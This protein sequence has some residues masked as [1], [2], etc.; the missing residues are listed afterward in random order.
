MLCRYATA[1]GILGGKARLDEKLRGRSLLQRR[2]PSRTHLSFFLTAGACT[3]LLLS[4]LLAAG[5]RLVKVRLS[6]T[7]AN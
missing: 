4:V 7:S 5:R 2:V 3:I 6:L 1:I